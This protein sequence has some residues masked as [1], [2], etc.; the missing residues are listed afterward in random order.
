MLLQQL[1]ISKTGWDELAPVTIQQIWE[2]W[3]SEPPVLSKHLV[4]GCYFPR[5]MNVACVQLH[6][7]SDTLEGAYAGMVYIWATD[8]NHDAHLSLVM[9]RKKVAPIKPLT[10]PRLEL[11]GT[12]IVARL[13]Q[14]VRGILKVP[15]SNIFTW[16]DSTVVLSW[17]QGNPRRFIPFIANRVAEIMELVPPN[18]WRH[19][20]GTSNPADCVSRGL[21]PSELANNS[22]WWNGPS[23]LYHL[24]SN[25]PSMPELSERP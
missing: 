5:S 8:L 23:W 25:W 14:H 12:I 17:I 15:R 11:C 13:L 22:I 6:G 19:V 1:W 3:R 10:M 9:G 20:P 18:R 16:T 7:F 21:Y 4:L 24:E 2:R